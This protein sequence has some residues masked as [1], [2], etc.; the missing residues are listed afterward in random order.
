MWTVTKATLNI[1]CYKPTAVSAPMKNCQL[2]D[3]F[4]R[5]RSN[6]LWQW[7]NQVRQ[8]LEA[9]ARSL[10]RNTKAVAIA[11]PQASSCQCCCGFLELEFEF[12]VHRDRTDYENDREPRTATSTFTQLFSSEVLITTAPTTFKQ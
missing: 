7:S 10:R 4:L 5:P 11:T 1:I 9:S 12:N 2:A 3:C 6:Q 8:W